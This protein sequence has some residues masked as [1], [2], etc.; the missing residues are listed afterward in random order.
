V[1]SVSSEGAAEHIE[2]LAQ[3]YLGTPY[4]WYGGRDQIRVLLTIEAHKIHGMG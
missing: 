1:L 2:K 4:P 3:R